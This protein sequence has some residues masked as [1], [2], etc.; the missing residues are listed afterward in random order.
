MWN[1]EFVDLS[2]RYKKLSEYGDPLERLNAVMDWN[3]FAPLIKVAFRKQRKSMAGRKPYNR[4]MMFKILILQALY[5]LADG[6]TEFQIRDRL[7][8]MRFLG[9]GL[10]DEVPDEKTIWLFREMLTSSGTLDKL[11]GRF[12]SFLE[13]RGYMAELGN[14]IDA[15]IVEVP[16]QRNSKDVNQKIKEGEVPSCITDNPHRAAQKD[17]Q[18]RWTMKNSKVYFGYKNHINAD[19]KH[20]IVRKYEATPA[21]TSDIHCFEVLLDK[22]NDSRVWADSAYYSAS[23]EKRLKELGYESRLIR[24]YKSHFPDWSEQGRRNSRYAKVRKRVEHVFGFMEN[25][26]RG[27]FIRVIGISRAKAKIGLMNLAYNIARY[28]QLERLGIA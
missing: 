12:N 4:L 21:S 23:T 17:I 5:N 15:S 14:M 24:R 20:K 7:S 13:Q 11:F 27:M 3:I 28:E 22:R 19:V 25:S 6:Q 16:K 9:L 10:N 2:A 26:M 8:F 1:K 18:A